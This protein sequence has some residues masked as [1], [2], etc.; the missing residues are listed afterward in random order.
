MN[1]SF[2]RS[3]PAGLPPPFVTLHRALRSVVQRLPVA[4]PSLLAARL[5]D[6]VL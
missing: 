6:R 4:P 2:D 3:G 1:P 5:L